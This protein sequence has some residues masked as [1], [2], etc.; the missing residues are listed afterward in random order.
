MSRLTAP[1]FINHHVTR[2]A[3][4]L[5]LVLMSGISVSSQAEAPRWYDVEVALIGYQ[6][7][8]TINHE[9]WPEVL[10][11]EQSSGAEGSE[12]NAAN[13]KESDPWSWISW[14]NSDDTSTQDLYNVKGVEAS[15]TLP[16][17]R[18]R[19]PFAEEGIA[20]E[21][22][23]E[24]FSKSKDLQVIWSRKWQQPIPEKEDTELEENAVK[25]NFRTPLNFEKN[26]NPTT[27]LIE[28]EVTGE[29]YLYR[30]RY[31]H[32][33]SKLNIQHWQ[34]LNSNSSLDKSIDLLPSHPRSNDNIIP[35]NSSTPL[36]A[37]NEIPIRAAMVN[38]SRR[39][40]SNELHYIDHPMLGILVR[41]TPLEE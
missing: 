40:R 15:D 26:P 22:K 8:Q 29:L 2:F 3:P 35:S 37:I 4:M 36:T 1:L 27:P 19:M 9:N 33:V 34:S 30:S 24:Q 13:T 17:P 23:I 25:I 18:L 38:Q 41:V 10:V 16:S 12:E 32:L 14:W 7:N 31:L 28:A 11:N 39:M 21:D 20:F 5:W 6:D